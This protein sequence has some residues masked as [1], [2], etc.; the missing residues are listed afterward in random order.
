MEDCN[1]SP[2]E[3]RLREGEI[4]ALF[5]T[6]VVAIEEQGLQLRGEEGPGFLPVDFVLVLIGYR[7]ADGLLRQAGVAFQGDKPRLSPSFET[8]VPGLFAIGSCGCGS[9]TRSVFI[10]NGR[11]HARTA[12]EAIAARLASQSA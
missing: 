4:Q 5:R 8:S 7:A 3:N 10:E 2:F 11:E 6:Q 12:V 9:E 1:Q